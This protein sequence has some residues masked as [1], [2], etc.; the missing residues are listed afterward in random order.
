[1]IDPLIDDDN[2]DDVLGLTVDAPEEA[3]LMADNSVHEQPGVGEVRD[4]AY[5]PGLDPIE[6]MTNP[7]WAPPARDGYVQRWIRMTVQNKDDGRN[8][9]T[10]R[11]LGWVPRSIDSLE[12]KDRVNLGVDAD[13]GDGLIWSGDLVLCEM[14]A[15]R[16]AKFEEHS[17]KQRMK[18]AKAVN[19]R[20][21]SFNR[22]VDPTSGFG[23]LEGGESGVR[24]YVNT[25]SR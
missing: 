13:Q 17:R 4:P 10:Q 20:V 5:D 6:A 19:G 23:H 16:A 24:T 14:D 21:D 1:M 25:P 18:V 22:K 12:A 3:G 2:I 11:R 9:K 15:N 7:L 8:V